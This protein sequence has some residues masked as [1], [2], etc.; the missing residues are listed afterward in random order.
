MAQSIDNGDCVRNHPV[1]LRPATETSIGTTAFFR[2]RVLFATLLNALA[3][4]N[5]KELKILFLGCS[6]GAE[7]YSFVIQY[8]TKAYEKLFNI[9]C[10]ATDKEGSF[11]NFARRAIYP[12]QILEGMSEKERRFFHPLDTRN[13]AV[14]QKVR[15]HVTFLDPCRAEF[16]STTETYDVVFLLNL[17]IYVPAPSQSLIVDQIASYN[18]EW[19][20]TSAFHMKSIKADLRRNGYCPYI[21]NI[22]E[23][24]EA[25]LDRRVKT[26]GKETRPGIFAPWSLPEFS[27]VRDYEYLYCALFRKQ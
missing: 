8:L 21:E 12:I 24:H 25:W 18:S 27:R 26:Y 23:I 20:I 5:K 17:L 10:H 11:I 14:S 13:V 9:I 3:E 22:E 4:K 6:I 2:N 16:F 15:R 19:F 7:T 1:R